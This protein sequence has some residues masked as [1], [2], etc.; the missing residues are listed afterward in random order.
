[1]KNEKQYTEGI[2]IEENKFLKWFD[3]YWYHHKWLTIGIAFALV[4]ILVCTIQTCTK[5]KEDITVLYAGPY[6]LNTEQ[7]Y[8]V[9][10]ILDGIL[11]EDYD[12]DGAKNVLLSR[13]HI[14]S[15]EQIEEITSTVDETGKNG[16][17]DLNNNTNQYDA[18]SN[19]L[20][21]GESSVLFL[22]PWLYKELRDNGNGVLMNLS[23]VFDDLPENVINDYGI[24]LKDTEM[25]KEYA[26]IRD[27]PEN[28]VIC[29]LRPII[30]GKSYKA[31]NYEIEKAMFAAITGVEVKN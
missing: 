9:S 4:V 14:Y 5:E 29:L 19:Y 13:Y 18:Y 20:L 24:L 10:N 15:R 6:H 23:E 27:I 3:N 31:E 21:T 16:F 7:Y 26:V 12:G 1:M 25:Y 17:V 8:A 2:S 11:P 30:G 28:T 22:D